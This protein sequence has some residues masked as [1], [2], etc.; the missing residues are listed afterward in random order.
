MRDSGQPFHPWGRWWRFEYY[1]VYVDSVPVISVKPG[2]VPNGRFDLYSPFE[3]GA[4]PGEQPAA[5]DEHKETPHGH[6]ALLNPDDEREVLEFVNRWGLLGLWKVDEYRMWPFPAVAMPDIGAYT[7]EKIDTPTGQATIGLGDDFSL[8][9]LTNAKSESAFF[10]EPHRFRE[11]LAL[12]ARAVRQYQALCDVI[13]SDDETPRPFYDRDGNLISNLAEECVPVFD[14]AGAGWNMAWSCPSLLHTI[15][16]RTMLDVT[17]RRRLKR[18]ARKNCRAFFV[19]ANPRAEYCS[20]ACGNAQKQADW[21]L[22]ERARRL[23]DK[24]QSFEEVAKTL[25]VSARDVAEWVVL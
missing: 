2:T 13:S 1:I 6:L 19:P 16:L 21:R 9:Y 18:C 20:E 8:W 15:Y 10:I 12:F 24:G 3:A 14:R 23:V 17:Q 25:N 11:P 5:K 7:Y 22:R 4:A